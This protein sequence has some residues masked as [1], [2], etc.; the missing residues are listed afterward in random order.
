[1]ID[2]GQLISLRIVVCPILSDASYVTRNRE[3]INHLLISCLFAREYWYSIL[4]HVGLQCNN[5]HLSQLI[6]SL[7]NGGIDHGA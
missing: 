1:M 4:C 6:Q 5:L 3:T 7:M 2:V